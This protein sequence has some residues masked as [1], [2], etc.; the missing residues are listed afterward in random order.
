MTTIQSSKVDTNTIEIEFDSTKR[1]TG[2][3][4]Y[5]IHHSFNFP[6]IHIWSS[7]G[8]GRGK[9]SGSFVHFKKIL[10]PIN[11]CLILGKNDIYIN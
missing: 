9:G 1:L 2:F 3:D 10:H 4:V 5:I 7:W 11:L 8:G 6:T